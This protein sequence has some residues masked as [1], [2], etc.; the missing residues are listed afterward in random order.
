MKKRTKFIAISLICSGSV[1]STT[2]IILMSTSTSCHYVYDKQVTTSQNLLDLLGRSLFDDQELA[3]Y[4]YNVTFNCGK[5]N[6]KD[7]MSIWVSDKQGNVITPA[8]FDKLYPNKYIPAVITNADNIYLNLFNKYAS[9]SYSQ[10]IDYVN[11]Q[12]PGLENEININDND[13]F[14]FESCEFTVPD[15][16]EYLFKIIAVIRNKNTRCM[17]RLYSNG[18]FKKSETPWAL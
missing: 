5:D 17:I 6:Y 12:I 18:R 4:S 7:K 9:F 1:L 2:G 10:L 3:N 15:L 16:K 8:E 13:I 14:V 11:D